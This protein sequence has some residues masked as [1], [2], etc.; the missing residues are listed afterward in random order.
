MFME[1]I[2]A[3]TKLSVVLGAALHERDAYTSLHGD[4]VADVALAI[5]RSIGLDSCD[6]G[7]LRAAAR[8]HDVGKIGIPDDVLLN[9]GVLDPAQRTIMRSHPERGEK[10]LRAIPGEDAKLV[11]HAIRHHHEEFDGNGYPDNLGGENIPFL[12]RII[13]IADNYDA[14]ASRRVY[15]RPRHHEYVIGVMREESGRKH[16]P[17]LFGKFL[18]AI[19]HSPWRTS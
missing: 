13:S 18:T 11:A 1:N 4:R 14:M 7:R 9:P 16:D 15:H 17:Y 19:E 2:S 8:L 10:I 3:L 12:A 6:L 5:G